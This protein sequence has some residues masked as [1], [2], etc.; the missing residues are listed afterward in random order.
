MRVLELEMLNQW[1]FFPA[2]FR[3]TFTLLNGALKTNLDRYYSGQYIA[4]LSDSQA[5]VR[6]LRSRVINSKLV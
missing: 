6:A 3:R 2:Y 5:A 4:I 1:E